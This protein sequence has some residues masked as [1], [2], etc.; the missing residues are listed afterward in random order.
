MPENDY[1]CSME[2]KIKTYGKS[3]F[4][5]LYM[6]N[7]QPATARSTLRE[8]IKRNPKLEAELI[9]AGYS[10]R[11]VLLTPAQVEIFFKYLGKP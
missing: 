1:I 10:K 5:L 2:A 11:A 6:P 7:V 9:E 8:W 3:E 4:A